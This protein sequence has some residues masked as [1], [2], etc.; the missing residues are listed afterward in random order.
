[1]EGG[2]VYVPPFCIRAEDFTPEKA[3]E[4]LQSPSS[5]KIISVPPCEMLFLFNARLNVT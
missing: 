5:D 2:D 4:I 1:M 3:A